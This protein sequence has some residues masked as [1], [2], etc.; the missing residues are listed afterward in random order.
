MLI[1]ETDTQ[2]I[3]E[4][5]SIR[6]WQKAIGHKR[7]TPTNTRAK[8]GLAAVPAGTARYTTTVQTGR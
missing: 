7:L 1:Y 2:Y 5:D 4:H 8:A 3:L 6:C